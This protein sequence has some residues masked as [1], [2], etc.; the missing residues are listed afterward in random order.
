[1][2]CVRGLAL[3]VCVALIAVRMA[4][5]CIGS[6]HRVRC[7]EVNVVWHNKI[8]WI[9]HFRGFN[10][11]TYLELALPDRLLEVNIVI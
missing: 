5:A 11:E 10:N 9:P 6:V 7:G 1:M 3:S 2:V 8:M 4:S